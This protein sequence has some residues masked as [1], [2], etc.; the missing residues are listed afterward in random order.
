M[1]VA[2][3]MIEIFPGID[4]IEFDQAWPNRVTATIDPVTGLT[5][6]FI[7]REDLMQSE[8]AVGR[9]IDLA[10]VEAIRAA[11]PEKR[12]APSDDQGNSLE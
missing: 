2:P 7:S 3:V 1:G 12:R 5:A 11:Q 9:L 6:S 10:D 4:G 8:L